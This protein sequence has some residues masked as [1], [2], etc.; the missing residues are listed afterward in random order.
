MVFWSVSRDTSPMQPTKLTAAIL[1][2]LAPGDRV[3]DTNCRGL[4]AH[5]GAKGIAW[6]VQA[7]LWRDGRLI[8]TCKATIGKFPAM[9]VD[10]ARAAS[11]SWLGLVH[12][13][14]DPAKPPAGPGRLDIAPC[15]R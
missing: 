4:I 1:A 7:D 15:D 14:V 8:R 10:Q 6:R 13:G 2:K 5:R 3:W 12:S 9:S 11:Q